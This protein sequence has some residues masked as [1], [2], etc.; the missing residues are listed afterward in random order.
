MQ[1]KDDTGNWCSSPKDIP[2]IFM[3]FF[4]GMLG[5]NVPRKKSANLNIFNMGSNCLLRINLSC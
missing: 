5:E 4:Q 1:L 2:E 3:K